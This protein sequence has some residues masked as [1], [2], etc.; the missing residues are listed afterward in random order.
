LRPNHKKLKKLQPLP[1][2]DIMTVRQG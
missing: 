1:F 2:Y